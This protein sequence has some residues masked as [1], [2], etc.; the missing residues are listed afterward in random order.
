MRNV[1]LLLKLAEL[2]YLLHHLLPDKQ[3]RRQERVISVQEKVLRER[4]QRLLECHAG[5]LEE[6]PLAGMTR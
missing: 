4:D 1:Q 6:V 3:G 5:T 2:R